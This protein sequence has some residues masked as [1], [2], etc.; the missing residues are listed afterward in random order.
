MIGDGSKYG[1][2]RGDSAPPPPPPPP[3]GVDQF[4]ADGKRD[5]GPVVQNDIGKVE[6]SGGP[7][8]DSV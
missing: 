5:F 6:C 2:P 7:S 4:Q 8:N 3:V 1:D